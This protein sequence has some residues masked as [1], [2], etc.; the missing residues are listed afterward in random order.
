MDDLQ[1]VT[2]AEAWKFFVCG[3]THA[4]NHPGFSLESAL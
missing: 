2:S 4:D 3:V 1:E